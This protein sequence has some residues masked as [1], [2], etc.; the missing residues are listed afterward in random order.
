MNYKKIGKLL[1][2][3]RKKNKYTQEQLAKK[4]NISHQIAVQNITAASNA[5]AHVTIM[6]DALLVSSSF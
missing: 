1:K 3:L 5:R 4:I 2:K 6:I